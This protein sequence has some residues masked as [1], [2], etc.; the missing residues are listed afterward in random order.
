MAPRENQKLIEPPDYAE[1]GQ[2]LAKPVAYELQTK[3]WA[4]DIGRALGYTARRVEEWIRWYKHIHSANLSR[5]RKRTRI[6]RE[7]VEALRQ[8][9]IRL[10]QEALAQAAT[11]DYT[12]KVI[13]AKSNDQ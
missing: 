2:H 8:E 7:K 11:I 3:A 1:V 10:E 4:V 6:R 13:N 5:Y 9:A 12:G